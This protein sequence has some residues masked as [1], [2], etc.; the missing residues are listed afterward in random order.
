[1]TI[2]VARLNGRLVEVVKVSDRVAFSQDRGWVLI[3]PDLEKPQ[4]KKMTFQWV[5]ASTKFEWV[6]NF[7]F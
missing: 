3:T 2:T 1:M 7:D 6:R 4:R 5:P